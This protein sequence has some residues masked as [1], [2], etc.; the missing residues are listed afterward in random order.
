MLSIGVGEALKN[1]DINGIYTIFTNENAV[2]VNILPIKA[3]SFC[4]PTDT[5]GERWCCKALKGGEA[6]GGGSS[7]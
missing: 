1:T 3:L 6:T 2:L 5:A 4:R 7:S